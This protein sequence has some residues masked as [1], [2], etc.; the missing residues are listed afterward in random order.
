MDR[1][2]AKTFR[3]DRVMARA[4]LTA[5]VMVAAKAKAVAV[6]K[7]TASQM[8]AADRDRRRHER[9]NSYS[10]RKIVDRNIH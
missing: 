3:P 5:T 10:P 6:A 9:L 7:Q 8:K 2:L 1:R 4:M